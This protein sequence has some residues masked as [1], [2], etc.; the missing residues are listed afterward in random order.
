MF[1]MSGLNQPKWSSP[2]HTERRLRARIPWFAAHPMIKVGHPHGPA[3]PNISAC[4]TNGV[5][6]AW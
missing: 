1:F 2:L 3:G 5:P 4:R 6:S